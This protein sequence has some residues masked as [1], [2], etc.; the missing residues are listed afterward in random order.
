MKEKQK[1]GSEGVVSQLE[2]EKTHKASAM[3]MV[4]VFDMRNKRLKPAVAQ[5]INAALEEIMNP[6]SQQSL[7]AA[8][9]YAKSFL[10]ME[11]KSMHQSFTLAIDKLRLMNDLANHGIP[12]SST[13][14]V[15]VK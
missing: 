13:Q 4:R 14:C 15:T 10:Q 6:E 8:A 5:L 12:I 3:H 2:E 11:D 9:D 1:A 7:L